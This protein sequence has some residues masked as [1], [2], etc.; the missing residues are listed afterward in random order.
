MKKQFA[1]S[2]LCL[3]LGF[4]SSTPAANAGIIIGQNVQTRSGD[5]GAIAI[6]LISG[7]GGGAATTYFFGE[8]GVGPGLIALGLTIGFFVLEVDA[9]GNP[10]AEGYERM[11]SERYVFLDNREAIQN[12]AAL[13][14]DRSKTAETNARGEK[15]FRLSREEV[16]EVLDHT[17]IDIEDSRVEKMIQDLG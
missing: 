10:G 17:S 12:L 8:K 16:L 15:S 4:L 3:S 6:V 13:L 9:H 1:L 14:T 11:L 7:F 2:V 5:I